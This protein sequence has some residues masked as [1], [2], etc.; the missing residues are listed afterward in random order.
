VDELTPVEIVVDDQMVERAAEAIATEFVLA[1]NHQWELETTYW[2]AP[3]SKLRWRCLNESRDR[4][5]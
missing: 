5:A 4:T 2:T 3:P 1:L